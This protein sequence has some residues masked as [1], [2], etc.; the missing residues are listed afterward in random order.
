MGQQSK[1]EWTS[2]TWN[3]VTGCSKVSAGCAHCY[4]EIMARRLK[5]M[6]NRRYERGFDV[7]LHE[8]LLELPLGWRQPR[9]VFVNSM[10]D[11]FHEQ[12]PVEF[13]R[14]VFET[15]SQADWHIFQVLTKRAERLAELAP[16]LPWPRNLWMGVTV[17]CQSCVDR[18]KILKATPAAV[19]FVSA[20]PLIGPLDIDLNGLDWLIVG[21]ESGPGARPIHADWVRALRDRCLDSRV[22]FFF[23]QWG[24][25]NKKRGGRELDGETWS[26]FPPT[27]SQMTLIA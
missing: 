1:I 27:D 11:L 14:R 18:A 22:P 8:D 3:P 12:V 13:I 10:S 7:N 16:D 6:G 19:K 21:G 5:A 4:A 15:I 2:A 25:V 26:Q 9:M 17:E 24:G 20:E 23:K